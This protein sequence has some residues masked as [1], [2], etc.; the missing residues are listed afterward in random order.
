M[1]QFT[2]PLDIDSLEII[3]QH[4]DSKGNIVFT[5]E[6]KCTKTKCH[7]CGKDAT[8]RYGY[9]APIEVR[10]TSILD[11]PVI[12]RIKPVRYQCEHCDDHP[13]TTEQYDWVA[14]GG[15]ITKGLER[16]ILRCVINST[17][18]DVARKERM[19][20]KTVQHTLD[21][22]ISKKVD[23]SL[24]TDLETIGIDEISNRK[25]HQ[26]FIAI[27]SAKDKFGK[28]S[29]LAV[30]DSRKK[31]DVLAFLKSIPD[32]LKKTVKSVCTDMYDG[33]VNAAIEVFGKQRVVVDRYHV[34][35]LYRNALDQ[36]R[37]KEMKCLKES[38][39]AEQY[40]ELDGMMWILR[41]KHEC[42]NQAEKEAL[43]KLY[44]HSPTLKQAHQLALKLTHI[45][46]THDDRKKAM[47]KINRWI[48]QV[49]KS[50]LTCF[51]TFIK[52]LQ[53]HQSSIANYFK[54]RATS[55]FV[56]GLNNKIKV[57]KRRCYGFFKTESLFQRLTLDLTG[58]KMLGI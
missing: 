7:K 44:D 11:T 25:G 2:L 36:L 54:R 47:A 29:T 38:L 42:L 52:T 19:S 13:T 55:G 46:N 32:H 39:S 30:L 49:Q 20:Y 43:K 22:L 27:I 14:K 35:K 34:S 48:S 40:A 6:S 56:E 17:I 5:V 23:W 8:K 57:I 24:H 21:H 4:T 3:S 18:Q 1:A 33:F 45:C 28:L 9:S 37:T 53:K 41:K 26:D 50:D 10:H 51:N 12:L 31:D 16:Y 15:K 58:Y